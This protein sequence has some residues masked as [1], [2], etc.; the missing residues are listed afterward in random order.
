VAILFEPSVDLTVITAV[1]P[2]GPLVETT[3]LLLTTTKRELLDQLRRL[4]LAFAGDTDTASCAAR[5]LATVA[6]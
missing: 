2:E 1:L 4:L 5:L 3:P 6:G